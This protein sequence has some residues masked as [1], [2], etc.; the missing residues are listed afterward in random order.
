MSE[1]SGLTR[2]MVALVTMLALVT[3]VAAA[4][5][6]AEGTISGTVA[7]QTKAVLP[8]VVVTATNPATGFMREA[9]TDAAGNFVLAALPPGT[10]AVAAALTGFTTSSRTLTLAVGAEVKLSIALAVG[11][12]IET[13]TVTGEA[14][15]VDVNRTEQG[16]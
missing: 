2:T 11:S 7:D 16:D 10:Y 5:G 3:G 12:V 6:T 9:T 15:L 8:G 4:Q 13:L 14:T 1:S